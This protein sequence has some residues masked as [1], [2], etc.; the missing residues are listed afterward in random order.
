MGSSAQAERRNVPR[1]AFRGTVELAMPEDAEAYEADGVDLSIGGMS[2]RTS[3]LPDRGSEL[4]CRFKLEDGRRVTARGEVVWAQDAGND[5]GEFGLRFT[6]LGEADEDAIRGTFGDARAEPDDPPVESASSEPAKARL[7]IPGMSAP[8]RARIRTEMQDAIVLG[9]DLSFL[10]LGEAV[11][12]ERQEGRR[13]QGRIEDVTVEVDSET[14]IARLML[15]VGLAAMPHV[16][17]DP[18]LQGAPEAEPLALDKRKVPTITPD[19]PV[20]SDMQLPPL[21]TRASDSVLEAAPEDDLGGFAAYDADPNEAADVAGHAVPATRAAPAWL[22]STLVALRSLGRTIGA[23]AGPFLARA[24]RAIM[25]FV[26]LA[27]SRIRARIQGTR[28]ETEAPR[29]SVGRRPQNPAVLH[30]EAPALAPRRKKLGLYV[31]AG[32]GSLAIAFAVATS[33]KDAR[34][35]TPRP[36]VAVA[37]VPQ[38]AAPESVVAST[39]QGPETAAAPTDPTG[40][41]ATSAPATGE[42]P[43]AANVPANVTGPDDM[44]PAPRR[45]PRALP[46]DLVAASRSRNANVN[47]DRPT[48]RG[49]AAPVHRAAPIAAMAPQPTAHVLGLPTVRAGTV[50]RMHMDGAISGL[51]GGPAAGNTLVIRMAGRRSLDLAAPLVR[52]DL[53]LVNASVYNRASGAEL[54]LRF[55]EAVPQ[56]QARARGNTLELVLAP[57]AARRVAVASTRRR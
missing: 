22:V 20:P 48:V 21:P 32:A 18:V 44:T 53:R 28:V 4:A 19:A 24:A 51:T 39:V 33:S 1:R 27:Y 11:E 6:D 29:H 23:T 54:T 31:L 16:T 47:T 13:E 26:L 35:R 56:Y 12:I 40:T 45:A 14:H 3:L 38:A 57:A 43:S 36:Q 7:H 52:Q 2:L 25:A 41:A 9:S 50:L 5:A 17:A 37:P 49:A 30:A 42:P 46:T 8:L 34:P 10:K 15:T 55:R